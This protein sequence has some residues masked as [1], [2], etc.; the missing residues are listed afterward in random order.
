[1]RKNCYRRSMNVFESSQSS[2][3]MR[4]LVQSS[5][6]IYFPSGCSNVNF[7]R[8]GPDCGTAAPMLPGCRN[9]ACFVVHCAPVSA[10]ASC[11]RSLETSDFRGLR[12]IFFIRCRSRRNIFRLKYMTGD[13]QEGQF[14]IITLTVVE[15]NSCDN[16]PQRGHLILSVVIILVVP[17]RPLLPDADDFI[18]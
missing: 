13:R 4:R 10:V 16:C 11:S 6:V 3:S 5:P 7:C 2:S 15:R 8:M 14:R 9:A 12:A 1:M 17:L 18:V